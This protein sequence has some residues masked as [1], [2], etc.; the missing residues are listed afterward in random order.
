MVKDR[1]LSVHDSLAL[2]IGLVVLS[3]NL[4]IHAKDVHLKLGKLLDLPR[5][6][7]SCSRLSVSGCIGMSIPHE[8]VLVSSGC[9][10]SSPFLLTYGF[11]TL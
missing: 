6:S 11:F 7:P 9:S 1:L 4:H 3:M 8:S 5:N 10:S 2:H